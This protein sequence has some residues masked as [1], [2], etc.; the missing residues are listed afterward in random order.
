MVGCGNIG[1][2]EGLVYDRLWKSK[3]SMEEYFGRGK[4]G[5]HHIF[6]KPDLRLKPCSVVI[7]FF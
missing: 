7:I 1:G 5:V 3:F 4:C 2:R 6:V